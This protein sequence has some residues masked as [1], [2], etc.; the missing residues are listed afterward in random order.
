MVLICRIRHGLTDVV[1]ASSEGRVD[2]LQQDRREGKGTPV[3]AHAHPTG[4]PTAG[5]VRTHPTGGPT[6]GRVRTHPTGGPTAGKV[7]T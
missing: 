2:Q 4:G 3:S 5:R 7:Q 1:V 6:A